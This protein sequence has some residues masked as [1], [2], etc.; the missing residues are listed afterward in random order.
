[1]NEEWEGLA[2]YEANACRHLLMTHLKFWIMVWL[3]VIWA[4]V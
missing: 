1:M 3:L 4:V 2:H